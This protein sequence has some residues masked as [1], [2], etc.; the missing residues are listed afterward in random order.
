MVGEDVIGESLASSSCRS[1][2]GS[3]DGVA[4]LVVESGEI[5][6][7]DDEEGEDDCNCAAAMKSTTGTTAVTSRVW[8]KDDLCLYFSYDPEKNHGTLFLILRKEEEE[9]WQDLDL[10]GR[11]Q[12]PTMQRRR[13]QPAAL[14]AEG[15]VAPTMTTTNV[16]LV[17]VISEQDDEVGEDD[18][19]E[20]IEDN[21]TA[22]EL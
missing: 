8:T 18:D 21:T 22:S 19:G 11:L 16:P 9:Y 13:R 4:R 17:K 3:D 12:Q 10:L 20:N 6:C 1:V 15:D 5:N 14:A 7:I 2:A